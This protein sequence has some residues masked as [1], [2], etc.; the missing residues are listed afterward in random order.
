[1]LQS[2]Y[3]RNDY[4]SW[5]SAEFSK[6]RENNPSFSLRAFAKFLN[7]SPAALSQ[8]LSGKREFSKKNILKIAQK[9]SLSPIETK[10]LLKS[11]KQKE[12]NDDDESP[13]ELIRLEND[14]F[15]VISD[16]YHIAILSLAKLKDNR[17]DPQWVA[18]QLSIS[19]LEARDALHRLK[20][21]KFITE[22]NG[23]LQRLLE[24]PLSV[25]TPTPSSAIRKYHK[26]N[27]ALAQK[28]IDEVSMEE[29]ELSAIT[30]AIDL[31]KLDQARIL[32]TKFKRKLARFLEAGKQQRVY[33]LSVQLFPVSKGGNHEIR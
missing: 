5:L 28:A 31:K 15:R 3:Y 21:L 32:I 1:M 18:D 30:M 8:V 9:F 16:W 25:I 24:K 19:V 20:R 10:E 13:M 7:I 2:E 29:R 33:T 6:K 4:R 17:S 23:K 27:L 22:K 12:F 26:Q 14:R 11:A